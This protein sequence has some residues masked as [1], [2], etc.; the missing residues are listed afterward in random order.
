MDSPKWPKCSPTQVKM[1]FKRRVPADTKRRQMASSRN[2]NSLSCLSG[3]QTKVTRFLVRVVWPLFVLR[4]SRGSLGGPSV[5]LGPG[6]RTV[7]W[8]L[9]ATGSS[10]P[11]GPSVL[12]CPCYQR[13]TQESCGFLSVLPSSI[14]QA[15]GTQA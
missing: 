9:L 11:S 5:S 2:S 8:H 15:R 12:S 10:L 13:K 7:G 4:A 1:Y 3:L 6:E 14:H